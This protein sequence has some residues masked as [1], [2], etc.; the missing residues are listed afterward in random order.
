MLVVGCKRQKPPAMTRIWLGAYHGCA[1]VKS[2]EL[3]CWGANDVGQLG[4]GT[5]NQSLFPV[6]VTASSGTPEEL[7]IGGRHTCGLFAGQVRCWGDDSRHQIS[8]VPKGGGFTA[9]SASEH[10]TCVIGALGALQCWGDGEDPL[11]APQGKGLAASLVAVGPGR[12]CAALTAPA[13]EVRCAAGKPMLAGASIKGLTAGGRHTCALLEDGTVQCWGDNAHGQLGD[14][15]TT[16]SDAPVLVHGLPAAI[17]IRASDRT[18]CARLWNNTVACWGANDFHQLANGTTAAS[19]RPQ[20]LSG[21]V[22]ALEL[23]LGGEGACARLAEGGA[24]CWGRNQAGQL[25]DGS[26]S[27]HDVPMPVRSPLAKK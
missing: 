5:K 2:G 8:G 7:A 3:E 22:G 16:S 18:T 14:G 12:V 21:L 15:S 20:P 17:E 4:D 25:G 1:T 6:R 27:D 23:A 9:I 26:T 13:R 11:S 24:R 19:A 10:R